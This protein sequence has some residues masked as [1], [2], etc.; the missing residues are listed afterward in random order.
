MK[1]ADKLIFGLLFGLVFPLL[2]FMGAITIWF[3]SFRELNVLYFVLSGLFSGIIIDLIFLNKLINKALELPVWLL[4]GFYIFYYICIYGFF[5]GFPVFNLVMGVI[6]G[7]YFGI[8]INYT[9]IS[10]SRIKV[11]KRNVSLFTSFIMFLICISSAFLALSEKTIGKELQNMLGLS[12]EVSR[13]MIISVI[14][15]GGAILI[16]SQYYL[17]KISMTITIKK[18]MSIGY[19]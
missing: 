2:F 10:S 14:L 13:A 16:A 8:K 3:Y 4:T 18:N 11:I 15:I 1:R 5:M 19:Q 9:D 7:Y 6:A 12:F 17:T